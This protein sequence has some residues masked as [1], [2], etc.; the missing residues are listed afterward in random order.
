M[1]IKFGEIC[2][3]SYEEREAFYNKR[4]KS[5]PFYE[6]KKTKNLS[7][8]SKREKIT[9]AMSLKSIDITLLNYLNDLPETR[10]M[11]LN[12]SLLVRM[13]IH[14]LFQEY[15]ENPELFSSK[16]NSIWM[17]EQVEDYFDVKED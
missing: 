3:V 8:S 9:V 14:V 12:K 7:A 11:K 17:G 13:M 16:L 6:E 10:G 2:G 1:A 5:Q 15:T 4:I